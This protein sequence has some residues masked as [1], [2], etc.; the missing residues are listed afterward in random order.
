MKRILALILALTVLG[1]FLPNAFAADGDDEAA[2]LHAEVLADLDLI[3]DYEADS[4]VTGKMF[5]DTLLN[6][7]GSDA[8]SVY[9]KDAYDL[10][11]PVLYGQLL[12]VLVDITGYTPFIEEFGLDEDDPESYFS[13]AVRIGMTDK[14]SGEFDKPVKMRDYC[15]I[16]YTA[17]TEVDMLTCT[18]STAG[19]MVYTVDK[20][21]TVLNT[22]M[23][24]ES[25]EGILDGVGKASFYTQ[26]DR[27]ADEIAIDGKWFRHKLDKNLTD[28]LGLNVEVLYDHENKK[29]KSVVPVGDDKIISITNTDV[30]GEATSINKL[31]Y[32]TETNRRKTLKISDEADFI[33]NSRLLKNFAKSDFLIDDCTYKLIDNDSDSEIDVIIA[34]KYRTFMVDSVITDDERIIDTKSNVYE[35][36]EYFEDGGKIYN[37]SGQEITLDDIGGYNIVSAAKD[38]SDTEFTRFI[39]SSA[40]ESGI[41]TAEREK[42]RFIELSGTQYET[43][44]EYYKNINVHEKIN[45]GDEVEVF[46]DFKGYIADIKCTKNAVKAG[47]LLGA[48]SESFGTVSFKLL[49]EEGEIEVLETASKVT[50]NDKKVSA[51]SLKSEAALYKSDEFIPQLV[52][53]KSNSKGIFWI[54]TAADNSEIGKH[55]SGEF[56]LD[57]DWNEETTLRALS[58]NGQ[59]V[60][61]SKYM[62]TSNTKVFGVSTELDECYVQTGAALPTQTALKCR[63]YNVDED[64]V[65]EYI[66]LDSSP[67]LGGWVDVW[68]P[69]YIVDEV[70]YAYN[71]A[72]EEAQYKLYYHD[73]S[74]NSFSTFMRAGDLKTPNGNVLSGDNRLRQVLAKDLKKGTVIQFNDDKYGI[75]SIC[76]QAMPMDDD[77]EYIFEKSNSTTG[78]EYGISKYMFNGSSIMSYGRVIKRTSGG[79]IV[80]SHLPT[81]VEEHG[82]AVFPMD[83]WNRVIPFSTADF[84]W[85]YDKD[86][87]E[88]K[89]GQAAEILEGDMIFMHRR[90]TTMMTTIV[91]R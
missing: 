4:D 35:F 23:E 82:G 74:G 5:K 40:K 26:S 90:A 59:R 54:D 48:K 38:Y 51:S 84:V 45:L 19:E 46:F 70:A 36:E 57:Y 80:N 56:S 13:V 42:R 17:L 24:L 81:D 69:T 16:L 3:S 47:Y 1:S 12:M 49:N 18:L 86:E 61:G 11:Q 37:A 64:Y 65:P 89:P 78:A 6:L 9:F 71:D 66:V 21:A 67:G 32:F 2:L 53:Y 68:E 14:A 33:Y 44:A 85:F 22:V 28:Y 60:L 72:K 31:T 29:I 50:L 75:K 91:Y 30:V 52:L 27:D 77:S 20:G 83:S 88:L 10:S 76:I 41:F 43:L 63:L 8:Y 25:F 34:D 15:E 87:D 79:I 58:L 55:S 39:V 73:G 62:T 7:Y